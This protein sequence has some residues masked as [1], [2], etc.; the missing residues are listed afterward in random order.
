[1]TIWTN[2][3]YL[4]Y[5]THPI[6]PVMTQDHLA[7][8]LRHHQAEPPGAAQSRRPNRKTGTCAVR[9]RQDPVK[10]HPYLVLNARSLRRRAT[11]RSAA[12][13]SRQWRWL[14]TLWRVLPTFSGSNP[15]WGNQ[16]AKNL[17]NRIYLSAAS[18]PITAPQPASHPITARHSPL[19]CI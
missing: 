12:V 6:R 15:S 19:R 16:A 7:V 3:D 5:R 9:L 13:P 2:P 14:G 1:M 8:V 18:R 4:A 10:P 17:R 11:R